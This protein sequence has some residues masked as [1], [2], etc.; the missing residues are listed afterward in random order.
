MTEPRPSSGR[1][2]E[3]TSA[4]SP[5]CPHAAAVRETQR[6]QALHRV[7]WAGGY[8]ICDCCACTY[9]V[10]GLAPPRCSDCAPELWQ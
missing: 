10:I 1:W 6:R 2:G 8:R 3:W 7:A 9:P 5:T 4:P